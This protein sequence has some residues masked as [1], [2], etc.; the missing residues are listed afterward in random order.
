[1]V[2]KVKSDVKAAQMTRERARTRRSVLSSTTALNRESFRNDVTF[3]L[4]AASFI[5]D[6]I[7]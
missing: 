6:T 5:P 2:S 3:L 4:I 1:M 7:T